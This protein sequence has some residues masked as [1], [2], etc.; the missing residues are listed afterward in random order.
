[1]AIASW[2]ARR[3]FFSRHKYRFLPLLT[4][5]SIAGV[6]LG[7]MALVV[8]LSVMR[9]F[10]RELTD[11]LL[12]FNAHLTIHLPP[13]ANA[14][15]VDIERLLHGYPVRDLAPIVEG[16]VIAEHQSGDE[17]VAHG[18]RIRGVDPEFLGAMGAV[19]LYGTFTG[20]MLGVEAANDL[21]VHPDFDQEIE[22]IAPLAEVGPTGELLPRGRRFPVTGLF[23]AG[24]YEYDG[25]YVLIARNAARELLG[26]QARAA[27]QVRFTDPQ[28]TTSIRGEL[29]TRLPEGWTVSSW[30]EQNKKLF[31]ALKLERIG[32]TAVLLL[33]VLIASF[34]IAGCIL[35]LVVVKR[36]DIAL[37]KTLGSTTGTIRV[38]FVLHG[39]WI[40]GVGSCLGAFLGVAMCWGLTRWP[41]ALPAS[42]YLDRLPVALSFPAVA[43]FVISGVIL[44][45]IASLYPVMRATALE[46]VEVFRYE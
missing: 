21:L 42:Y 36:R 14:T 2:I 25:H 28:L 29:K 30:D 32:M 22:L 33:V 4:F 19:E 44:A 35:L 34:S 46:I 43:V 18:V 9:G 3:Y 10:N 15:R 37:L 45:I 26:Q 20:V 5:T 1:M 24:V 12:G 8:V 41:I 16:E 40:G 31:A 6:A 39:A 17:M 11:R 13:E 38:T 27:W 23:R 7:V